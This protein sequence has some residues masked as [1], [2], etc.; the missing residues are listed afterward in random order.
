MEWKIMCIV[1]LRFLFIIQAIIEFEMYLNTLVCLIAEQGLLREQDG[2]FLEKIKRAGP[3][4]Q[5][6]WNILKK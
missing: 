3:I 5:A 1:K 4:K 6:G 2:I